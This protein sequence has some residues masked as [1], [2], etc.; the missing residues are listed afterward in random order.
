MLTGEQIVGAPGFFPTVW[1]WIKRWFDP[2]TTSKIFILSAAEVQP[3]LASFMDPASIPKQYGGELE[4]QWGDMPNLDEP[5]SALLQGAQVQ[6]E[7]DKKSLLKGP[8]LFKGDQIE[9]VGTENG[10]DRR[11]TIPVPQTQQQ[12]PTSETN[13]NADKPIESA[14]DAESTPVPTENEKVAVNIDQVSAEEA[15]T[16]TAAA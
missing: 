4:W 12:K 3:T 16:T 7:G 10:K 1:G 6:G 11:N 5:A 15:Q 2:G 9:V 13:E 14:S 8:M